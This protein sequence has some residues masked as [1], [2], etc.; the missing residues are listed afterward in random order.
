MTGMTRAVIAGWTT[1][2][3][4][5]TERGPRTPCSCVQCSCEGAQRRRTHRRGAR[6]VDDEVILPR[7]E[8][9]GTYQQI[10]ALGR[11]QLPNHVDKA[12]LVRTGHREV[13]HRNDTATRCWR[14]RLGTATIRAQSSFRLLIDDA[15]ARRLLAV[16]ISSDHHRIAAASGP[17]IIA[18]LGTT[19]ISALV[20]SAAAIARSTMRP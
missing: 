18:R 17:S 5:E 14:S 3:G 13:V 8:R 2:E 19:R 20:A 12:A 9:N 10:D 16:A 6:Q 7:N 11:R 4:G 15:I 1:F